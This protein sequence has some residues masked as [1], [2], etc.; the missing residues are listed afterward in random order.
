[1]R[2]IFII[3]PTSGKQKNQQTVKQVIHK[4]LDE[5]IAEGLYVMHTTGKNS[6]YETVAKL[7]PGEYDFIVAVGGDGTVSEVINGVIDSGSEIPVAVYAAGTTNDFATCLGLPRSVD[8]F[9]EMIRQFRTEKVDVG[10]VNGKYFLNVAAG[11]VLS[12]IAHK[13]SIN[14][15]TLL[16][17]SAYMLQ[18]VKELGSLSL[19]TVPLKYEMDNMTLIADT[20]LFFLANSK[21]VGGF[22]RIAPHAKVNDGKLDLCIIKKV[23]PLD[24]VPVFTQIQTGKH[25]ENNKCVTYLQTSKIVISKVNEDDEFPVDFDGEEGNLMP[26]TIETVPGALNLLVPKNGKNLKKVI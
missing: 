16:G 25:I 2:G 10:K 24:I 5:G 8:T 3:N 19:D 22:H 12:E 6:A 15:K 21:S 11:G 18:G 9:V 7:K 13:V 20:F 26:L 23:T 14:A 4:L 17:H 1:M